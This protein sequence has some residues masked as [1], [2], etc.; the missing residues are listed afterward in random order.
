MRNSIASWDR[1]SIDATPI[2]FSRKTA[3]WFVPNQEG[4]RVL[5][6]LYNK[7]GDCYGKEDNRFLS[8]LPEQGSPSY[9]GRASSLTLKNIREL[10]FHITNRCNMACSH[11]LFSSSPEEEAELSAEDILSLAGEAW[12]QGCRLFA[13]TGGE[14]L[15]HR[16]I[17]R[18]VNGILELPDTHLVIL[19]NG[20]LIKKLFSSLNGDSHRVHLQIS[21]DGLEENHDSLRGKDAFSKLTAN[22]QWL[23]KEGIFYTLSM[24]VTRQNI[25]DM[26]PMIDFAASVGAK[27]VHFMWYFI[28]GRGTGQQFAHPEEL[29]I[30]LTLAARKAE[31]LGIPIDNIES[32]K[33]RVFSPPGTIHDGSTAGWES[34]AIGPDKKLYPSAALIGIP[35]LSISLDEGLVNAWKNSPVLETVRN[36]SIVDTASPMRFI[37]GGGDI[38]HSYIHNGTFSG[39]DPYLP[40]Y[41]RT[42]LW[43]IAGSVPEENATTSNPA[44][45]LQ[46]GEILESCSAHGSI[47]LIHSNCLLATASQSSLFS[48]Q[49][50]Y[51]DAVGD[52]NEAIL[53]PVGYDTAL[54]NHIPSEYRF[55]GYGCGSPVLDAGIS[56]G[57]D[58]VDLGCGNGVECFIASRLTGKNGSVRG[59]DMLD[60]MLHMARKAEKSVAENLGYNNVS[61]LTGYLETLPLETASADVVLSN[62]VMNLS[63]NKR[64][65]YAE[66]LRVLRPGGKLVISDVVCETE[67]DAS[68]SNDE[69]LRGECIA[70]ALSE[71]HLMALLEET[72]FEATQ[73]IKRFPYRNIQGH[74]FYS[75]TYSSVKPR[76][77][78]T[79]TAMYRGPLP[80]LVTCR[81]TILRPGKKTFIDRTE[82]EMLGESL[83]IFD[84]HDYVVNIEAENC[85]SCSIAP[86]EKQMNGQDKESGSS[87]EKRHASGCM[88]CGEQLIYTENEQEHSCGYCGRKYSSSSLCGKGHYVCD[89]CHSDDAVEVI[90]HICLATEETDMIELMERIRSHPSIPVHGPEY[91]AMIPG[92]IL[93]TWR[94]LGGDIH[95]MIIE[96]GINRGKTIPGGSCGFMGICGAATGTG[97]AFS[98]LLKANPV[99]AAERK[100]VQ[101]I[102]AAVL[103]E[104]AALQAAR[105]CQRDC[106]IALKKAAEL[107]KEIMDIPLRAEK[108]LK[109]TQHEVNKECFG[110]NCPIY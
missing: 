84:E 47:A 97:I 29:F 36:A 53:N 83:F 51:T 62:C 30:N 2:Y 103:E 73:L 27:N 90:K 81:G 44:L 93:A 32:L 66:I 42:V 85:C 22:L 77:T 86:D 19:T 11:C 25:P 7:N 88:I 21:L 12:Q 74:P 91:H 28:R 6:S 8:R 5:Q 82:A 38:D 80:E 70:G 50:F 71:S 39:S 16:E 75:L 9:T 108:V 95:D 89:T 55:R 107:S 10:W 78:E 99:K 24:C 59:I 52:K 65:A 69:T 60:P 94:N 15:V 37:L 104:I 87:P 96:S 35:E 54:V 109:C 45:R 79:V 98:I 33:S 64:K 20:L 41:E 26:E 1:Y 92:I 4:D 46:M 13:L 106:W 14:P 76:L 48:I 56:E 67:P 72:G 105:C 3:D 101:Q 17:D 58:I 23:K 61:F 100:N 43:L 40:L 34:L 18:I 31:K 49:D 102:T 68:I 63:V 57:D 110:K